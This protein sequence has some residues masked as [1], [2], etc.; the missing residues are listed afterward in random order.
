MT[1]RKRLL[2]S[3]KI[4]AISV[5]MAA[6]AVPSIALAEI[7]HLNDG[8]TVEGVMK[9]TEDGYDITD[10]AGKLTHVPT[11][12]VKRIEIGSKSNG[13]VETQGR[14]QSLR[15]SVENLSDI[16]A[17]LDRYTRFIDQNK[18]SPLVKDALRDI[19]MWRDRQD[20]GMVKVGPQWMT[21]ADRDALR[22]K[23]VTVAA[24]IRQLLL[25]GRM[26]DAE[27]MLQQALEVDPGNVS[28]LFLRGWVLFKQD[29]LPA[30]RKAFEAV[31]AALPD[32]A[33]TLN[34]LAVIYWRQNQ[35]LQAMN[36]YASAMVAQPMNREILDNVAEAL[37]ALPQNQRGSVPAQKV[38]RAFTDQD[39]LMQQQLA[40]AGQHRWGST[41]VDDAQFDRLQQIEKDIQKKLSDMSI[42][43]DALTKK[44]NG[45]Q[46]DIDANT[47]RMKA[48][49]DSSYARDA[50]GNM[51]RVA[52]PNR[53][54]DLE[55]ENKQLQADGVAL[56]AK[57]S[58]MRADAKLVQQQLTTPRFTGV[59][60]I[61][62]V[63][64]A[65]LLPPIVLPKAVA[66]TSKPRQKELEPPRGIRAIPVPPSP[67]R[68][69]G[70]PAATN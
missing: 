65:P 64:N 16:K 15:R 13:V 19:E 24:E 2:L 5:V 11:E 21:V 14:L 69:S 52:L 20:K 10:A 51:F 57:M 42:D 34:N 12:S 54:Y 35:A 70:N 67:G 60:R 22:S 53:Y 3:P 23:G 44:I 40:G 30:A 1:R 39:A 25:Q 49:E 56:N 32:H 46:A 66:P 7:L 31:Q 48:M 27:P 55:R 43:F 59:Q 28:A 58:Q 62:G 38:F 37:N 45:I 63:E 6:M 61:I 18:D 36:S 68:G 47:K 29:Q 41:W 4:A 8:S 50:Q 9:R 17:I 26:K 33:P